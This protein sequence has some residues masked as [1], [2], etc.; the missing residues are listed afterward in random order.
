MGCSN[1]GWVGTPDEYNAN[2]ELG[3]TTGEDKLLKLL[4]VTAHPDD[5]VG[6][7]GGTLLHCA[8]R[9]IETH[10]ICMTPGQ[11]ATYRGG[12]KSDAELAAMRRHEFAEACRLLKVTHAEVL[13]YP[14]GALDRVNLL[15]AVGMLARRIREIR[16]QVVVT[17]GPEGAV[18]AHPDHSMAS[19][20]T[21]LAYH[22]A[23]RTNRFVDE[24][25]AGLTAH[26]A[27]KLYYA[28]YTFTLP[29][30][31]PVSLAPIT[32]VIDVGDVL[33][34]KIKAFGT[35]VSQRPLL[36]MFEGAVRQRGQK[37]RF[38][39][40]AAITPREIRIETDLFKDVRDE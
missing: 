34:L 8:Q 5:E 4:C 31:Q 10:V 17:I 28:T 40:V 21:T 9:G 32:C 16:P 14:D 36:P 19:I 7:F 15:D 39:L 25:G 3:P 35:H 33:D 1:S 38:H 2:G 23:G 12:A 6:S 18:T 37:E 22:W 27:Q 30:R 13:D 11:A 29:D 24:S 20:F 26:R